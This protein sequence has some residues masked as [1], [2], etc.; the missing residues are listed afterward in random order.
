M[1]AP[2]DD[3]AKGVAKSIMP[4][5][6]L[7]GF[8]VAS[9]IG[10]LATAT[11]SDLPQAT[12]LRNFAG[13]SSTDCPKGGTCLKPDASGAVGPTY[14]VELVNSRYAVYRKRDGTLVESSTPDEFWSRAGIVFAKDESTLNPRLAY[15]LAAQ[16]WYAAVDNVFNNNGKNAD[17]GRNILFAISRSVDPT[18]GWAAFR[19]E[20]VTNHENPAVG[21][22]RD[23]VF[24][25]AFEYK[26][27]NDWSGHDGP[28]TSQTFIVLPK[29][30]LLA[31]T[32]SIGRMTILD[33][34]F[35][36]VGANPF[37]VV[38]M[39]GMGMPEILI[40]APV[41]P[42]V[43]AYP[44]GVFKRTDIA[45]NVFSP[46]LEV[47]AGYPDTFFVGAPY[48]VSPPA[49]Q[50][51]PKVDPIQVAY[52][53]IQNAPVMKNGSIWTLLNAVDDGSGRG[54][55][56]WLRTSAMDNTLIEEGFIGH[57]ELWYY[58]PSLAVNGTGDVVIG[59]GACGPGP[60]Q[61]PS[62]YAVIGKTRGNRTIFGTPIL[63]KSGVTSF[64]LHSPVAPGFSEAPWGNWSSTTI[65]PEDANTFW[66]IQ[67]WAAGPDRWS[68]QIT[69]LMI[70]H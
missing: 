13:S 58:F 24:I 53:A 64:D 22:N 3:L 12:I 18:K 15:D 43:P 21:F 6:A 19:I 14:F 60:G 48:D 66:T 1:K 5:G 23:G 40:V 27:K 47:G 33:G 52:P 69:A 25:R 61:Y 70:V 17:K 50:P 55:I 45:G 36:S 26:A 44:F 16:R 49:P 4:R 8:A 41:P 56:H 59:F 29:V 65:D 9:V 67:E 62:S 31:P 46:F 54:V 20:L 63:L 28:Y 39:D 51:D 38:D 2:F 11:A 68:T 10:S 35:E 42:I 37:P 34:V 32:P 30:D 57:P 7:K